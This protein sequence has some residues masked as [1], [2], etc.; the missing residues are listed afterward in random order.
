[1]NKPSTGVVYVATRREHYVAEAFLS[2]SSVKDFAPDLPNLPQGTVIQ[3]GETWSFQYW[4]RD[5]NP[6]STSNTS[7]GLAI[8][9]Q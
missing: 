7:N 8:A 2:A 4:Y 9:F 3:A 6:G 5:R 1:M